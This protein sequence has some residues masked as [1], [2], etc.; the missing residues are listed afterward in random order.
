MPVTETMLRDVVMRTLTDS[1][2]MFP[3]PSDTPV[4]DVELRVRI[5]FEGPEPG[6]LELGAPLSF[7]RALAANLL[8]LEPDDPELDSSAIGALL[9]LSNITAG[10][11]VEHA[12]GSTGC[13]LGI[14]APVE[15]PTPFPEP[16]LSFLVDDE[17]GLVV[18]ITG[19]SGG[20]A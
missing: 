17:Y 6:A 8:G 15:P 13:R 20:G 11:L 19:P 7:A 16:A 9:E 12:W 2:F 1:A 5:T 10:L 18:A 3:F 4:S 14:P